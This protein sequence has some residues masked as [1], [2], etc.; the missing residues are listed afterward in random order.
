MIR[1]REL[2][3]NFQELKIHHIYREFNRKV[4]QLYMQAL[5]LEEGKLF[6]AKGEVAHVEPFNCLGLRAFDLC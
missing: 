5:N 6:F 3:L 1:I 4:D 2:S